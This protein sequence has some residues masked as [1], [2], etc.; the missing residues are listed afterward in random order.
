MDRA[1]EFSCTKGCGRK[2]SSARHLA[3]HE[4]KCSGIPPLECVCGAVFKDKYQK[5]KHKKKHGCGGAAGPSRAPIVNNITINNNPPPIPPE[6]ILDVN[7][8]EGTD[9][10]AVKTHLQET[11][12]AQERLRRAFVCGALHE[13]LTR[14]THFEGPERNRNVV[15]VEPHGAT[16][17]VVCE[18]SVIKIDA[19]RGVQDIIHNNVELAN[20]DVVRRILDID[21]SGDVLTYPDN[22][23]QRVYDTKQIRLVIENGGKYSM[24]RPRYQPPVDPKLPRKCWSIRE[25][26]C[27]AAHQ[28]WQCNMCN[29]LLPS[30]FDIDHE[31]PLFKGGADA[32]HNLQAL[33]VPCHRNKTAA[34]R[35]KTPLRLP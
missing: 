20:S 15:S 8:Y 35:S 14:I 21:E 25:R 31:I 4:V 10:E 22:A 11:P 24:P 29:D 5:Y 3:E 17:K 2:L 1:I 30:C 33:C 12:V 28:G 26:H 6:P 34:E 32:F 23:R 18:K 19:T 27:V 9:L 16:M 7:D 13:E